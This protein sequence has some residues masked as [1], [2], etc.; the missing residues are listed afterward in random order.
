MIAINLEII[1]NRTYNKFI[2]IK[3]SLECSAGVFWMVI[4]MR[5]PYWTLWAKLIIVKLIENRLM[6]TTEVCK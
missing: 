6:K 5:K 2:T 4:E 3:L 1:Y